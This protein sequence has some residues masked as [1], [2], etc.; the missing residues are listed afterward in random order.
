MIVSDQSMVFM[1]ATLTEFN[2]ETIQTYLERAYHLISGK[3][4]KSDNNKTIVYL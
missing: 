4:T 2:S 1:L 3:A